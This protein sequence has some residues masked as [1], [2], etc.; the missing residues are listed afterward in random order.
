MIDLRFFHL[1]VWVYETEGS[2]HEDFF[3]AIIIVIIIII[4]IVFVIIIIMTMIWD[5]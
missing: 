4:T 3:F 2:V 5:W 1:R